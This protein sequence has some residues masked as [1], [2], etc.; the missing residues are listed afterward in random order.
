LKNGDRQAATAEGR[1][2]PAHLGVAERLGKTLRL[3]VELASRDARRGVQRQDQ[4]QLHR[5]GA[6]HRPAKAQEP[7]Q[8]SKTQ[9]DDADTAPP[10]A[11]PK[12]GHGAS[13]AHD[14]IACDQ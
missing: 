11:R 6:G 13:L 14:L 2:R 3:E 1:D 7:R 9:C 8:E 4:F 12:P 10:P 5:L